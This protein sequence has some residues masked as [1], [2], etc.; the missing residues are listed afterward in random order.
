MNTVKA[1]NTISGQVANVAAHIVNHPVLGK[2]LVPVEAEAKSYA[3]EL[4]K[5]KDGDTFKASRRKRKQDDGL[6]AITEPVT[7]PEVAESFD[8]PIDEDNA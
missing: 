6:E 4:Y 5:P 2:N 8:T 1:L 3:P 7:E